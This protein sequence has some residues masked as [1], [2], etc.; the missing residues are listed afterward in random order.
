MKKTAFIGCG[1][2]GSAIVRAVCRSTDP[3][4]IYVSNR[5]AEKAC[6]LA[7]DCGC[8]FCQS[9]LEAVRG[10]D[11]IILGVKPWQI[12]DVLLQIRPLLLGH[13]LIVSMAAGVS[14]S[15]IREKLPSGNPIVRILPNTPCAIGKGLM[16]I[17]PCGDVDEALLRDLEQLLSPCGL[18]F[19]TDED[20]A[21]AGM[22]VGGC[23][24]AFTYMFI[25]ALADGG[26][27]AGL[28]RSDALRW[29]AQAVAGAA[30]MVLQSD[31]HPG[32]LKDAVCSPGGATIEGV[33][34][35][36]RGAFRGSVM[37]AVFNA[38][39]KSAKLGG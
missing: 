27:K 28:K 31:L 12:G 39:E 22:T 33:A 21:E 19:R 25:E 9:N 34:T 4:T 24:P 18:V 6:A 37:D 30:E 10:A 26:V 17:A 20:H 8:I 7:A 35:L 1:N 13:E 36:E 32:A 29:A 14:G 2:M 11:C 38:A 15:A 3:E 5:S 23:T 16:L